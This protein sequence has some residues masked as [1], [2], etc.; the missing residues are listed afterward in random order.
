MKTEVK[1]LERGQAEITVEISAEEYQPF[2]EQAA[3]H[4]SEHTKIKGFRP[5]KASFDLI[6][7]QI[8]E[9]E[10][11][12]KA[13]E[14]AVRKTFVKALEENQLITVGSPKIDVIKVAPGN[15]VVYK[16]TI[17]F[18]PKVELVDYTKIKIEPKTT[19]VTDEDIQKTLNNLRKMHAKET[20]AGR[21]AKT[22]DKIEIDFE[23]F[24]DKVPVE[25]GEQKKFILELG[26]GS[27]IPGFEEQLIGAKTDETKEFQLKFPEKYHQKNLADKMVDFKVKINGVYAIELPQLTDEFAQGLGE[28]KTAEEL[29]T[30]IKN[31][32]QTEQERGNAQRLEEEM[33]D[34]IIDQSKFDDLPDLLINSETKKMIEELEHN[35]SHQGVK[36]DDYLAHLKKSRADLM[37][38]F[39]PQ[40]IKRTKS[41]LVLRAVAKQANIEVSKEDIENE[42]T[43]TLKLYG[44][45][46][47]AAENIRQP[48]Y[49]DYLRNLIAA[50]KTIEY[51]KSKMVKWQHRLRYCHPEPIRF[52]SLAQGR[53][54][55]GI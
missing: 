23:T 7:K 22:G 31:N 2:L 32:L 16:A 34:K 36:V 6:K 51:I 14:P 42:I 9:G 38:E 18:L 45:N 54:R 55:R 24:L 4:L 5:G 48:A 50:R 8:G 40:A 33:I 53:L 20:L 47:Q 10:I 17:S 46:K 30:Q 29:K 27:F 37:L 21:E 49:Q 44:G 26:E 13:L 12:Q 19:R 1:N 39:A 41:A 3:K 52:A 11:W 25:H 28:F 43:Q 15:P 35:I